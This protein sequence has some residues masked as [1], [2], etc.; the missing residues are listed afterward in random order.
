MKHV[1]EYGNS[2]ASILG[3]KLRYGITPNGTLLNDE[4]MKCFV[5]N[6]FAIML[7]LDGPKDLQDAQRPLSAG[8]GSYDIIAPHLKELVSQKGLSVGCRCTVTP[9]NLQLQ[10]IDEHFLNVGVKY[11][12]IEPATFR[13]FTWGDE[14]AFE[15]VEMQKYL[16]QYGNLVKSIWSKVENKDFVAY[17]SIFGEIFKLDKREKKQYP[18]GMGT[19]MLAVS[20]EGEIHTCH[21]LVGMKEQVLGSVLDP[22]IKETIKKYT[23]AKTEEKE[24]CAVCW[25]RNICAGDCPAESIIINHDEHKPVFRRCMLRQK[26]IEWAIWLYANIKFLSDKSFAEKILSYEFYMNGTY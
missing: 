19:N 1:V 15:E 12:H 7:S 17:R 23:P 4:L 26:R 13:P 11:Y 21:R 5:D 2:H 16:Q 20:A 8:K 6:N 18:C 9:K 25:V 22:N 3:K 14:P 24:G 10:I